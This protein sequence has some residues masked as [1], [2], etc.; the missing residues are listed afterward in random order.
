VNQGW[1]TITGVP[2]PTLDQ[3]GYPI[4]LGGL[5]AQGYAV[6]DAVFTGNGQHY[7]T[8]TYTLTFDGSGTIAIDDWVDPVQ[9]VTQGG[10]LGQP[11]NVNVSATAK[12]GIYVV[13]TSSDSTDYVRNIHLVMPG[14]QSTYQTQPFNSQYLSALQP[15][16]TVR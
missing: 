11:T 12:L 13:I 15:F 14:Y 3:N 7:P 5:P 1:P 4:G 8:G 2:L 10:G 9:Y 16:A 6:G